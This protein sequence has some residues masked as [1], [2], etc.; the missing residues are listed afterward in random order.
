MINLI[1]IVDLKFSFKYFSEC[2]NQCKSFCLKP[3]S[4]AKPFNV[5]VPIY[6]PLIHFVFIKLKKNLVS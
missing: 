6:L 4:H 2:L 3:M 5:D 1:K